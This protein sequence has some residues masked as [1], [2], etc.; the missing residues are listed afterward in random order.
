MNAADPTTDIA[1]A[2]SAA[3]SPDQLA[4]I[5][6]IALGA[7]LVVL[8]T[9]PIPSDQDPAQRTATAPPT[10]R[11]DAYSPD[12]APVAADA[13]PDTDRPRTLQI[14]AI[15]VLIDGLVP[16]GRRPDGALTV[17]D[18]YSRVG[19]YAD[20]PEPGEPGAAVIAG[21]IDSKDGPA[22]FFRLHELQPGQPIIIR[23]TGGAT[24]TFLVERIEQHPKQRFP[25]T[26]VY[27]TTEP[28]LRL[29]TCGGTFDHRGKSYRDNLIVYARLAPG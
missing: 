17:P 14:P 27:T 8:A 24:L 23:T 16:L 3:C 12:S 29:I 20:G 21:H 22:A 13:L 15:G 6:L 2:A 28:S 7:A 4:G 19:W 26:T 10:T 1:S 9:A 11:S 5:G 18:D 25:T